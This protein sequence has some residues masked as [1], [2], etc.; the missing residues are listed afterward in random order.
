MSARTMREEDYEYLHRL[1]SKLWE[2]QLSDEEFEI[3]EKHLTRYPEAR[4]LYM[5]YVDLEVELTCLV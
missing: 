3:L 4:R 1:L 5:Q 2:D